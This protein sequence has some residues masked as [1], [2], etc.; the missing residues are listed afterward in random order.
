MC[1]SLLF[2]L[3]VLPSFCFAGR[4]GIGMSLGLG[5][6]DIAG[7]GNKGISSQNGDIASASVVDVSYTSK[8]YYGGL[9]IEQVGRGGGYSGYI[10]YK[11]FNKAYTPL[12]AGMNCGYTEI[13]F[14]DS[15]RP[16]GEM[17]GAGYYGGIQ[18]GADMAITN[19][20]YFSPEL[21]IRA[22]KMEA[23]HR[24]FLNR[25]VLLAEY[26]VY[27]DFTSYYLR[28]GIRFLIGKVN[29]KH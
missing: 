14:A 21:G 16:Y 6:N 15:Y 8:H 26:T 1:K 11:F 10:N 23:N 2:F 24:D 29:K 9:R 28:I 25:N 18:I 22:G 5:G 19:F 13:N 3:L 27:R 20:I 12:Y 17:G 7:I 4:F